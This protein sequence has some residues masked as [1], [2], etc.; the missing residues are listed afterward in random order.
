MG[1]MLRNMW[2]RPCLREYFITNTQ[3]MRRRLIVNNITVITDKHRHT[4][5]CAIDKISE[6]LLSKFIFKDEYG[7]MLLDLSN[8]PGLSRAVIFADTIQAMSGKEVLF[9][10]KDIGIVARISRK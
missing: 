6:K 9:T 7:W 1:S 8:W 2:V 5:K 3:P 4:V 10:S